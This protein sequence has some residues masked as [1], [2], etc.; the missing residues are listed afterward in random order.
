MGGGNIQFQGISI[1]YD[2]IQSKDLSSLAMMPIIMQHLTCL[3]QLGVSE[4]I[5]LDVWCR[6]L[7]VL[8]GIFKHGLT[9][10]SEAF[11]EQKTT[12]SLPPCESSALQGEGC[13]SSVFGERKASPPRRLLAGVPW[14]PCAAEGPLAELA[15]LAEEAQAQGWRGA[16]LPLDAG[17][18]DGSL[19]NFEVVHGTRSVLGDHTSEPDGAGWPHTRLQGLLKKPKCCECCDAMISGP[20]S[21]HRKRAD[22]PECQ[23]TESLKF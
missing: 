2:A 7:H 6:Q 12:P 15:E 20:W 17:P 19:E 4:V 21:D 18:G 14:L 13:T 22:G 10:S 1:L 16:W 11:T 8:F 5:S 23:L 9:L 3:A